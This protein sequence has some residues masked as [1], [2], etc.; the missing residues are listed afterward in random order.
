MLAAYW[1][2]APAQFHCSATPSTV[3][4]SLHVWGYQEDTGDPL[5]PPPFVPPFYFI[6][7]LVY[8]AI[9]ACLIENG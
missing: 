2:R 1:L 4:L 5:P 6:L 9:N 8:G 3:L 7:L